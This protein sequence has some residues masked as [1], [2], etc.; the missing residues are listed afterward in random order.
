VANAKVTC[1]FSNITADGSGN[2]N[3]AVQSGGTGG[4]TVTQGPQGTIAESWYV[5]LTDGTN[6]LGTD[7]NPLRI[8]PVGTTVQPVSIS[9]SGTPGSAA[10][11]TAVQVGGTDGTDLRALLIDGSGNLKVNVAAGS[12]GNAAAS[13]TGAAVPADAGY[14]G[15]NSGG[16]LVGVSSSNPLPVTVENSSIAVTGTF[17][18]AT[19][20]VSGTF[21][22]A[23][24]PVSGTFWQTTQPVS[25]TVSATVSQATAASLNATVVQATGSNLHTVIDSGTVTTVST[26]TTVTNAVKVEGNAGGAFDAATGAAPPA[27][28]ILQGAVAASALPT[29]VTVT[30]LVAP[31][32]DKFGRQVILHNSIRDLTAQQATTITAS[33]SSTTVVT[34]AG[35]GVY[36]DITHLTI[37]NSSAT[38]LIVTLGDGTNSYI[39]ALAANGG[40]TTSYPT[41]L[42][43]TSTNTAWTLTCG[44]SV[45][46]IYV[47]IQYIK[48][49]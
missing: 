10:P 17:Y 31:M 16:N 23:T 5:E 2:L 15:F 28:A 30:D 47:V 33:T 45:S 32:A 21:W 22:Q 36:A 49:K 41:P 8:D 12:S 29:A 4:G 7:A 40:L 20:P 26:L 14:T 19:Q 11:S 18:Q 27:N 1:G 35:S 46:S 6:P 44:T 48:N 24:Q 43:A 25:G 38:A 13:A 9:S 42:V 39:Y 37:T 3:V 34:A